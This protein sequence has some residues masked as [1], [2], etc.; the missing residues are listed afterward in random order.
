M[1]LYYLRPYYIAL[2]GKVGQTR[3]VVIRQVH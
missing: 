1:N 2:M 3:L